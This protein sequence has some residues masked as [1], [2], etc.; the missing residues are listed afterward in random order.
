MAVINY[1]PEQARRAVH[2]AAVIMQADGLCR[3]DDVFKCRAV[4]PDAKKCV[5]CIEKWLMAK[6]K[7]EMKK[8]NEHGSH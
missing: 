5:K 6:A 2:I 1:I 7:S 3:Y 8:E 4:Y